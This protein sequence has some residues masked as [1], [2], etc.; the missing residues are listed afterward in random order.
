MRIGGQW[1]GWG[2]ADN[3]ERVAQIRRFLVAKFRWARE[4]QP[5]LGESTLFDANLAAA[6]VEMQRRYGIPQTGTWNYETQL[7]SGFIPP[8]PR[9]MPL[10]FT[11]C[12]TGVP[13]WVGPDADTARAVEDRYRWQP[14]G[15]PAA[16]L[17][18]AKSVAA[19]R[20]E[21][22]VQIERH[23]GQ[24]EAAGRPSALV[25]YSQGAIVACETWEYDIRPANGRLSWF[26]PYLGRAVMFGNPMREQGNGIGDATGAAPGPDSRGIADRLMT[27]TP[28]WFL[29]IAHRGDIYTD[30][31]GDAGEWSTAA[32]KLIMGAR[33]LDGPDSLLAQFVELTEAPAVE[34][35]AVF[36]AVLSAGLFFGRQ[37]GPHINYS[38]RPAVEHLRSA[39][40]ITLG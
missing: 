9:S 31:T 4:W 15:Y 5:P 25:G 34:A 18:M 22:I 37:T 28:P 38:I 14:I 32:Y 29:N 26:K 6:T 13:W 40:G 30:C 35:I 39:N 17:G 16:T 23:R 11:V 12:G 7:R 20:H 33:I 1:V 10:L 19:G 27:S 8:K 24:I 2:L 36:R 3:D 21:L